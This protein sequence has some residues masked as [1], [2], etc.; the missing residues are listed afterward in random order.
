MPRDHLPMEQENLGVSIV[1]TAHISIAVDEAA[2]KAFAE[3]SPSEREKLQ[4]LLSLSLQE[5]RGTLSRAVTK[6]TTVAE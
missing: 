5:P 2:A 4:L 3:A 1:G 6:R